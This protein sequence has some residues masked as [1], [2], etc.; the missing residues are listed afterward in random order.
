MTD[1]FKITMT[2]RGRQ[3]STCDDHKKISTKFSESRLKLINN[4]SN[5]GY[6]GSMSFLALQKNASC[7]KLI[8][9]RMCTA[10]EVNFFD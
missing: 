5:S 4:L 10:F 1:H 8:N 6:T 3:R 7:N 2:I 9:M